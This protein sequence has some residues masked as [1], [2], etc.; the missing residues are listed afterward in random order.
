[1]N[2]EITFNLNLSV[3]KADFRKCHRRLQHWLPD[4]THGSHEDIY[5]NK[6][7]VITP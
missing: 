1:M 3:L 7:E 5:G 6:K 4:D 2:R